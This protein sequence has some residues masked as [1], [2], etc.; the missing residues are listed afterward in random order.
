M[1]A[2]AESRGL[3]VKELEVMADH[4]HLFIGA[5]PTEYP[6]GIAKALKGISVRVLFDEHPILRTVFRQGH[7]WSPSYYRDGG[8][9]V[10]E[11]DSEVCEGSEA[12]EGRATC[13]LPPM[14]W[15]GSAG[16]IS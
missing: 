14:N 15:R 12:A 6:I 16:R 2:I 11:S 8:T 9:Y 4:V 10:C 13:F 1:T 5:H 3:E 7:P